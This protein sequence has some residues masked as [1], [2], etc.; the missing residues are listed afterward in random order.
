VG[1]EN[2]YF[3]L[4]Q[5]ASDKILEIVRAKQGRITLFALRDTWDEETSDVTEQVKDGTAELTIDNGAGKRKMYPIDFFDNNGYVSILFV[6]DYGDHAQIYVDKLGDMTICKIADFLVRAFGDPSAP[7]DDF[8]ISLEWSVED[9]FMQAGQDEV[10]VTTQEAKEILQWIDAK[11]DASIGVNWDVISDYIGMYLDEA[12]PKAPFERFIYDDHVYLVRTVNG[13]IVAGVDLRDVLIDQKTG[14]PKSH[15][16]A[17]VDNDI[18]YYADGS[19]M[20]LPDGELIKLIDNI[21]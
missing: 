14:L 3:N 16:E 12:K 15:H 10:E 7:E 1:Y 2:N 18:S 11:H 19:E 17:F 13:H 8:K 5:E 6:D 9:V 4:T 20:N 21:E